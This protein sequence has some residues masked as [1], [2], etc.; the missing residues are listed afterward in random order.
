M[1]IQTSH[2][3][4]HPKR[5]DIGLRDMRQKMDTNVQPVDTFQRSEPEP[6]SLMKASLGG[7]AAGAAFAG[8]SA[9]VLAEAVGVFSYMGGGGGNLGAAIAGCM[10]YGGLCGG[11]LA[12]IYRKHL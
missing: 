10:A 2:T 5:A 9:I 11:L 1:N 4:L 6:P 3:N 12:G 8:A 7:A